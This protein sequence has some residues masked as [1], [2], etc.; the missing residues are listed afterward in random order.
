MATKMTGREFKS[1]YTD[2]WVGGAFWDDY[3][4][5]V[6]GTTLTEDYEKVAIQDTD[7]VRILSG[8]VYVDGT[9]EGSQVAADTFAR[10][11][12]KA[13]TVD[14][15]IVEI[16]KEHRATFDMMVGSMRKDVDGKQMPIA[17][18]IL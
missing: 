12:L 2:D 15:V 10:R 3:E 11:W 4:I 1:F 17:R 5:E 9:Y 13:R 7:R 18:I 16:D 14:T 8:V 6:N